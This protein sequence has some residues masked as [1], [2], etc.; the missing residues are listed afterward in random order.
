[1]LRINQNSHAD[2]AKSYY[3]SADYYTEGQ[4][5]T[6]HWRGKGAVMLGLTGEISK[7]DWDRMCDQLNPNDGQPL[8]Q[9]R[10][11]NRTI[12]YDFNFHVPKS[13]SVLYALT[14]DDRILDAF[15]ESVD[16]TM[17]DIESEMHTRVRKDGKN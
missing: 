12:G 15:Q 8:F 9:R 14:N 17:Q 7:A 10:K 2:G 5:L 1:M 6:G 3:S 4:E 13:V 11:S 16:A